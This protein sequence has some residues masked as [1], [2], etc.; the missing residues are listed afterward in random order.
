MS[1]TLIAV[2]IALPLL[3]SSAAFAETAPSEQAVASRQ[4]HDVDRVAW[5]K[6]A[7]GELYAHQ[8]GRLAY[9]EAKLDL[10]SQQRPAWSKWQQA[11]LD[12]AAKERS[13]CLEAAPKAETRPN[14]LE[15]DAQMEK[16]LTAKLQALQVSRPMLQALYEQLDPAQK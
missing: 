10:T 15:R 7:C 1:K 14:A 8:A 4:H 5:P 16:F 9:L 11:Q 6:K 13:A 12:T 2:L 3:M